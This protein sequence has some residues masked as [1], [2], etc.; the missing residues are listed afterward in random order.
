MRAIRASEIGAYLYCKRAWWYQQNGV[1]PENEAELSGGSE[2]HRR[3]GRKVLAAR[4]AQAVGWALLLAALALIAVA[5]T[6]SLFS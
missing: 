4:L 5:L 6:G 2:F 1:R 3:H